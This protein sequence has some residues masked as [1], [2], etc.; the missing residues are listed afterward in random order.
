MIISIQKDGKPVPDEEALKVWNEVSRKVHRYWSL[1]DRLAEI[2]RALAE[3]KVDSITVSTG[4]VKVDVSGLVAKDKILS[5][6]IKSLQEE[7]SK[8]T[9]DLGR[10]T[11]VWES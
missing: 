3:G 5:E 1:R 9:S 8:L 4:L 6:V 2:E 11:L 7:I 10:F